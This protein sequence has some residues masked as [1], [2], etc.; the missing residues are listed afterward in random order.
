MRALGLRCALSA[1]A[2]EGKLVVLEAAALS[3]PKTKALKGALD[4]LGLG[5]A[6]V[7]TGAEIDRNFDLA[8]RNLPLLSVLP[9][10][11]LNVYDIL[12][13]DTLVL[14]QDAVRSIEERLA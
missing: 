13:R 1:K 4:R 9:A 10:Q 12:R 6:L 11:G 7:V 2:G 14:T 5:S 3:E 8:S